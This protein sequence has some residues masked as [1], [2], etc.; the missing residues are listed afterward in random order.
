VPV[1]RVEFLDQIRRRLHSVPIECAT[2]DEAIEV[3]S[4]HQSVYEIEVWSLRRLVKR[5]PAKSGKEP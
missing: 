1:Y 5:F 2:D 3:G 4:R